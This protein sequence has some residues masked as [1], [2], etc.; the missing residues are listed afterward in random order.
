MQQ[1]DTMP[2]EQMD[3]AFTWRLE[4]LFPT[5]QD[6]ERA[7]AQCEERIA[8]LGALEGRLTAGPEALAQGLTELYAVAHDGEKLYVYARMRR[9]EDNARTLYQGMADRAMSLLVRLDSAKA[10]V[11]PELLTLTDETLREWMAQPALKD[12]RVYLR[13]LIRQ[14]AHVLGRREEEL[15]AMSGEMAQAPDT[16]YTMLADADLRFPLVRNERGEEVELTQ[17]RFISLMESRDREVRRNV[18]EKFYDTWAS[19]GNTTAALY[20]ASVKKDAFYAQARHYESARQSA[21]FDDNVDEAVYDALIDAVHAGLPLLHRYVALR[22]RVLGLDEIHMYDLYNPIVPETEVEISY[23][24]A[25]EYCLKGLAPLGEDYLAVLRQ[26]FQGD[27]IDVYPNRGKSSG[28]Y[29]WGV[30]GT[31]PYVL[32]NFQGTLDS[33]MTLAHEMGHAMHSYYSHGAQPYATSEYSIFVAEVASTVNEMLVSETLM[34]DAD[35]GFQMVLLNNLLDQFRGTVFRQTMF[36]EFERAVHGLAREGKAITREVLDG[37]YRELNL[38]YYGPEMVVDERIDGEWA[39]IP[40]FYRS[41]YVYQYATGF[42]AAVALSRQV[43][44]GGGAERY[45]AFLKEGGSDYPI[46]QLKRAGVD[47]TKP[48]AVQGCLKAF[49]E[50]LERLEGLLSPKGRI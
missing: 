28:A 38:R 8:S 2:R 5:D 3:P 18:F 1:T 50:A 44:L 43:R 7:Y 12:Y 23:E 47:L 10:F 6:W 13:D 35:R 21:L 34:E 36:A 25:K 17:G 11:E 27:W 37:L 31:H 24:R 19:V 26:A 46:E 16:I 15:L 22:K 30:Y 48:D 42:S 33:A 20:A 39:R 40:H 4:D 29:S 32:M 9:D 14:R 45:R 41:F 49:E